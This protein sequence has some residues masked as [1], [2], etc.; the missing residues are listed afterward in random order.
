DD[1]DQAAELGYQVRDPDVA[2]D[3]VLKRGERGRRRAVLRAHSSAGRHPAGT[4]G[5]RS[6]MKTLGTASRATTITHA[7]RHARPRRHGR[8]LTLT[9]RGTVAGHGFTTS[10]TAKRRGYGDGHCI[11]RF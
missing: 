8:L 9:P 10:T 7:G 11:P 2:E 1:L 6:F 3:A 5:M 4:A